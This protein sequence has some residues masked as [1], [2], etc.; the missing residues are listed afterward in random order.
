MRIKEVT[1]EE[2]FAVLEEVDDIPDV[3][4]SV[5]EWGERSKDEHGES[6]FSLEEF[7]S[8]PEVRFFVN[9]GSGKLIEHLYAIRPRDDDD[10]FEDKFVKPSTRWYY[11]R[12]GSWSAEERVEPV[13]PD[14]ITCAMHGE[15]VRAR[16]TVIFEGSGFDE[17]R[18]FEDLVTVMSD[19]AVIYRL[20]GQSEVEYRTLDLRASNS[21]YGGTTWTHADGT[22]FPKGLKE[23]TKV[24]VDG[25]PATVRY[26]QREQ[27]GG[28]GEG[29]W[30]ATM[31]ILIDDR[32]KKEISVWNKKIT[33]VI[34][35]DTKVR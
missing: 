18:P 33:T 17:D 16:R 26:E 14:I 2:F 6:V 28:H 5:S 31:L 27:G 30:M 19:L 29:S 12:G 8:W 4:L 9:T 21:S 35:V 13:W 22:A 7:K 25:V 3:Q 24:E 34:A 1:R 11:F 20:L 15:H 10:S 23:G 32:T